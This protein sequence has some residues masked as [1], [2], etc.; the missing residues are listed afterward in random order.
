VPLHKLHE[1]AGM[2]T[3]R[4]RGPA[5]VRRVTALGGGT[6]PDAAYRALVASTAKKTPKYRNQVTYV[7][8]RRFASKREAE[9]YQHLTFAERA[10]TIGFLECQVLYRFVVN[11][12]S[13][14]R[15]TADFR[16]EDLYAGKIVVEDSKGYRP[17][18]WSRTK[19]LMLACH[20][21][22]VREV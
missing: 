18:D 19:K 22:E 8:G 20:G 1:P 12:V 15:Y 11:G 6:A 3:R 2:V 21:I 13:V 5:T 9:R 10:G 14:G 7:D 16:Y 4:P 17:R